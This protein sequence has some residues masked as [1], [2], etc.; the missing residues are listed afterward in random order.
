MYVYVCMCV[1][2]SVCVCVY[3]FECVCGLFMLFVCLC[4]YVCFCVGVHVC[5]CARAHAHAR[6]FMCLM[7]SDMQV[8][9]RRLFLQD[10]YSALHEQP[11]I[12]VGSIPILGRRLRRGHTDPGGRRV[13]RGK[14]CRRGWEPALHCSAAPRA[15]HGRKSPVYQLM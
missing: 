1:C 7:L 2:L 15:M 4:M 13:V 14:G 3:V 12:E 11:A 10:G 9:C 8:H 5:E 6:V